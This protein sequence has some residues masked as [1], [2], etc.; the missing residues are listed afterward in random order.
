MH[1]IDTISVGPF[2]RDCRPPLEVTHCSQCSRQLVINRG[3][4]RQSGQTSPPHQADGL[5]G[6]AICPLCLG[7]LIL[8]SGWRLQVAAGSYRYHMRNRPSVLAAPR[9]PVPVCTRLYRFD[10]CADVAV[11]AGLHSQLPVCRLFAEKSQGRGQ[12]A[13]QLLMVILGRNARTYQR[14]M[15]E[16]CSEVVQTPAAWSGK[17]DDC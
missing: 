2:S 10:F 14:A 16:A 12:H 8:A 9:R 3:L 7:M 1:T 4:V 17:W 6:A 11:E 15:S 13:N 5:P